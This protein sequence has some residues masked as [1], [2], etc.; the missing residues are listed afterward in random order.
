MSKF[1][2]N[3]SLVSLVTLL[4]TGAAGAAPQEPSQADLPVWPFLMAIVVGLFFLV[5]STISY[6]KSQR[7]RS[8]VFP[9]L[10][11]RRRLYAPY[12]G[13]NSAEVTFG[14]NPNA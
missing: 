9:K 5:R 4:L 13:G 7:P 8:K 1:F 11:L 14:S 6:F 2:S 10:T 3:T 12:S